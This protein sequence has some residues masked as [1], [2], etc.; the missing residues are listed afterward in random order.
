VI[1]YPDGLLLRAWLPARKRDGITR[2]GR[3]STSM[4]GTTTLVCPDFATRPFVYV[5]NRVF[6]G[7]QAATPG[8]YTVIRP[9]PRR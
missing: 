9:R 1:A 2:I 8:A 5:A 4:T 6:P 3:S 7:H